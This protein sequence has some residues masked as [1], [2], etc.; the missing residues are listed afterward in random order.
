MWL[1]IILRNIQNLNFRVSTAISTTS[2]ELDA[3]F[4]VDHVL[5]NSLLMFPAVTNF[6]ATLI[7]RVYILLVN[8]T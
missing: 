6:N 2:Q 5:I 1:S 7:N 4:H 8:L 3:Y